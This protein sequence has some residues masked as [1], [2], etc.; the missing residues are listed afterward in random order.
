[1]TA[2]LTQ[3]PAQRGL[4]LPGGV[5]ATRA[6][7]AV[8]AKRL[9][10][11]PFVLTGVVLSA[12]LFARLTSGELPIFQRD[13]PYLTLALLPLAAGALIATNLAA[14]RSHRDN[15][16]ELFQS[17]VMTDARKTTALLLSI[18]PLT[19]ATAIFVILAIGYLNLRGGIGQLDLAEASTAPV[20]V[21]LAG[22]SGVLLA[23]WWTSPVSASI[24]IVCLATFQLYLSAGIVDTFGPQ[25]TVRWL[26]PW[27]APSLTGNPTAELLWRPSGWH[28]LYLIALAA[29]LWVAG[30]LKS[31]F[32]QRWLVAAIIFLT[33]ASV[34]A[35]VL[36]RGPS[37]QEQRKLAS[38][39]TNPDNAQTCQRRVTVHY[40][41]YSGYL[42][43]IS[44][45]SA[46]VNGVLDNV[47]RQTRPELR[48]RQFPVTD[49]SDLP[50]GLQEPLTNR[51]QPGGRDRAARFFPGNQVYVGTSWG[52][53]GQGKDQEFA[54]ALSVAAWTV[55][56]PPTIHQLSRGNSL[57]RRVDKVTPRTSIRTVRALIRTGEF[58]ACSAAGQ[59]RS[60]LALWLVGQSSPSA[61]NIIR[62]LASAAITA[63]PVD[64]T[65]PS[66]A[67]FFATG[68]P[69][70]WGAAEL[71]YAVQLLNRDPA[72]V[73]SQIRGLWAA[74]IRPKTKTKEAAA[75]LALRPA[76]QDG[77]TP[78]KKLG[79][80]PCP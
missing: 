62:A 53:G 34:A 28:L 46:I 49:G 47:P 76:S 35:A 4:R 60:V 22:A 20:I 9:L 57:V 38:F 42:P 71:N 15:T 24:L 13:L 66:G 16:G 14:T 69:I 29:C 8:E 73:K 65:D 80:I 17:A 64:L 30:L 32:G 7:A 45:W 75:D 19:S 37:K 36:L 70:R 77:H 50:F 58:E 78:Y 59:A 27:A 3:S 21:A 43:L 33:I 39:V 55:G 18:V 63:R 40:C 25:P 67:V 41:A 48:I 1:M 6:L 54:L 68:D 79:L 10:K 12:V 5:A 26:A 74:L 61:A 56:L 2:V 31:G 52:T 23:R 44:R 11:S 72:L 51:W